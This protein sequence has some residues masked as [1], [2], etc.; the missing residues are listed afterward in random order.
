MIQDF[1]WLTN[2]KNNNSK[3]N[4]DRNCV[5][6]NKSIRSNRIRM[7][8]QFNHCGHFAINTYFPLFS[9]YYSDKRGWTI[10]LDAFALHDSS[11]ISVPFII[12]KKQC[13]PFYHFNVWVSTQTQTM[14]II[15]KRHQFS[16]LRPIII[17]YPHPVS[18]LFR[19]CT[20]RV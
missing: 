18:I 16:G 1:S 3:I 13:F 20:M 4:V 11:L 14:L 12:H 8:R 5:T 6:S 19:Y 17:V 15:R 9:I 10:F 7:A 2:D